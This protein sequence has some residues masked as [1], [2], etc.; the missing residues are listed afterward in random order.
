MQRHATHQ[1][2]KKSNQQTDND[3][4]CCIMMRNILKE[5]AQQK[6]KTDWTWLLPGEASSPNKWDRRP[7]ARSKE[8]AKW[9]MWLSLSIA[10]V[11]FARARQS[12]ALMA[13]A[14]VYYVHVPMFIC[15]L[16]TLIP[17][18]WNIF[19]TNCRL[20]IVKVFER[21]STLSASIYK[22]KRRNDLKGKE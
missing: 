8:L 6:R 19:F 15:T 10:A 21:C 3:K 22:S 12:N 13:G 9:Q 20:E 5:A 7:H 16:F 1:A 4:L 14:Q 18:C 17:F 2:C 11:S